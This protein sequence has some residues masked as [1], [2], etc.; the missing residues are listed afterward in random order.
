[1]I[2]NCALILG[3]VA[4]SK[5]HPSSLN[6]EYDAYKLCIRKNDERLTCTREAGIVTCGIGNPQWEPSNRIRTV[7]RV[8]VTSQAYG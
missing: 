2:N 3:Q 6:D 5:S 7:T 1:M 8:T 4:K